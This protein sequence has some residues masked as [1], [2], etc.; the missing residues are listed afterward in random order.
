M[1]SLLSR[2]LMLLDLVSRLWDG[3]SQ[4]REAPLQR[5]AVLLLQPAR[6]KSLP[7]V[8]T[9]LT[10]CL[11]SSLSLSGAWYRPCVAERMGGGDA[12]WHLERE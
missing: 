9:Y 2:Q 3:K 6:P 10:C 4:E 7:S 11:L 12:D 5:L 1:E 8:L